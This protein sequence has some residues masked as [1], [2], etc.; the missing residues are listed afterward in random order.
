MI[1]IYGVEILLALAAGLPFSNER[2]RVQEIWPGCLMLMVDL[3]FLI[4]TS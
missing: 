2:E 1:A 3:F 4:F